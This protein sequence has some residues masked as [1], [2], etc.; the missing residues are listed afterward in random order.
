MKKYAYMGALIPF[1]ITFL[2]VSPGCFDDSFKKTMSMEKYL[3]MSPALVAGAEI[4]ESNASIAEKAEYPVPGN[5][6]NITTANITET[7]VDLFWAT[8]ADSATPRENLQYRV[9]RSETNNIR[10]IA[11]IDFNGSPATIWQRDIYYARIES[12]STAKT[13]YFNVVVMDESG[14]RSCYRSVSAVTSGIAL[15]MFSAGKYKGGLAALSDAS[16]SSS[17]PVSTRKD[18]DDICRKSLGV[19]YPN[20]NLTNARAFISLNAADSIAGMRANFGV[21]DAPVRGPDGLQIASGWGDLLDGTIGEDLAA[22]GISSGYWW[23]GSD[24]FGNYNATDNCGG[25][26]LSSSRLRG[27]SGFHNSTGTDWMSGIARNCEDSLQ[28]LCICW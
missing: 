21:P 12:L 18:V 28:L 20:L 1:L 23:S 13:Y 14:R 8:A 3:A 16:T 22:A 25:W 19:S 6:G 15:Y 10:T 26:T 4:A 9:Y 11:E 2:L 27:M 24:E 7:S 17:M 5:G